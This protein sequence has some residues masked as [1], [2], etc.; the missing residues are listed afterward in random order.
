MNLELQKT[1]LLFTDQWSKLC[2]S[3]PQLCRVSGSKRKST[4]RIQVVP[5]PKGETDALCRSVKG[6]ER[7]LGFTLG[8]I[9][10]YTCFLF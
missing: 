7:F 9:F 2:R 10:N 1:G 8:I 5:W 6:F 4:A 3:D